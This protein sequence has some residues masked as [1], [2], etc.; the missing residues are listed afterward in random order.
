MACIACL[1]SLVTTVGSCCKKALGKGSASIQH[2]TNLS[3]LLTFRYL[4]FYCTKILSYFTGVSKVEKNKNILK[5]WF[6]TPKQPELNSNRVKVIS[7]SSYDSPSGG[8]PYEEFWRVLTSK[9]DL[10]I[11][12][13]WKDI[14]NFFQLKFFN[15]RGPSDIL[16]LCVYPF[17]LA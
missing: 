7:S 14:S 9:S 12:T 2:I 4:W 16:R 6:W 5:H 11:S 1:V 13:K 15:Y 3:N 8:R 17:K 10:S